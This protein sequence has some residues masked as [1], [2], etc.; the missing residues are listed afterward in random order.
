[1]RF[2]LDFMNPAGFDELKLPTLRAYGFEPILM[3]TLPGGNFMAQGHPHYDKYT[4]VNASGED[5]A[6][7][8]EAASLEDLLALSADMGDARL[9]FSSERITVVNECQGC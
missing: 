2:K 5:Y 7:D 3:R 8:F 9:L 1:M 4:V 6:V